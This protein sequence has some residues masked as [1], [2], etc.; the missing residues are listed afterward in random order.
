MGVKRPRARLITGLDPAGLTPSD[1]SVN[2]GPPPC[3]L[4]ILYSASD[5]TWLAV[6]CAPRRSLLGLRLLVVR[7]IFEKSIQIAC[8]V[9]NM[10][11]LHHVE[12]TRPFVDVSKEDDVISECYTP[13]LGS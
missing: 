6:V 12:R 8:A 2:A 11:D 7:R 5:Q 3:G 4:A 9:Q 10:H 1:D 13:I